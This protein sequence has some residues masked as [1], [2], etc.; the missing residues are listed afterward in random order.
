MSLPLPRSV[1]LPSRRRFLTLLG[2]AGFSVAALAGASVP[3][4]VPAASVA[5]FAG[6][7]FAAYGLELSAEGRAELTLLPLPRLSFERTRIAGAGGEALAE[8]GR[9]TV[10]LAPT[11]LLAGRPELAAIAFDGG[12]VDLG[13]RDEDG[14][15]SGP[16]P[17][18]LERLARSGGAHP[19]RIVL[20]DAAVSARV[21]GASPESVQDVDLSVSWPLWSASADCAA[22]FVWRGVRTHLAV[23]GL[24]PAALAAQGRSPFSAILSWPDGELTAEGE[25]ALSPALSLSGEGRLEARAFRR[26]LAW[27]GGDVALSPF[28]DTVSL[29]GRFEAAPSAIML[30]SVRVG[31]GN[32]RFEGA[33]SASLDG[34]PA[35]QATLA[36]D[37]LDLGPLLGGLVGLLE[38]EAA[39]LPS[40]PV[41]LRPLTGGDLDLRVSAGASRVGPV[42]IEDI[43]AS[44]LV[45]GD[46]IEAS[47]NRARIAGTAVK[48]RLTLAANAADPAATE[49]RA[50]GSFDGLDIG[51]LLTDFGEERWV[52]GGTQG[53]F[54][55]ESSGRDMAGLAAHVSGRAAF[56]VDGGTI[57]GLDLAD[58]IHRNGT[59]A[60]GALA[61]RNGRTN[62]ERAAVSLKFSDGIGEIGEGFLRA[63]GISAEIRGRLSL[64]ERRFEA[65]VELQP[66]SAGAEAARRTTLFDIAGPWSA[67]SVKVMR[68]DQGDTDPGLTGTPLGVRPGSLNVPAAALPAAMRAYAP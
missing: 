56:A 66:R 64:P 67:V 46:A 43:A 11:A 54:G 58:V 17:A 41:A 50:Q 48:A 26:T 49:L 31:I 65:R 2:L 68:L 7:A 6:R 60:P 30:P 4:P 8:G 16:L 35:I 20:T 52:S 40:R 15:W 32:S 45:R 25:G 24:R 14:S 63:P 28:V 37:S 27:I 5:G 3:W 23:A 9:L 51:A 29:D 19:R 39:G 12:R 10:E 38:P 47:L 22:S 44:V 36:A 59:L 34:R 1:R 57:S 53:Q 21:A 62:F 61:R 18:L 42:R 33:M 55:L 13:R